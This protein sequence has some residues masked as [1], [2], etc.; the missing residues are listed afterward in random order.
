MGHRAA[1][2]T[3]SRSSALSVRT[4]QR[5]INARAPHHCELLVPGNCAGRD[6]CIGKPPPAACQ[7]AGGNRHCICP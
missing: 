6:W 4:G 5:E 1:T 2:G 7:P 3:R